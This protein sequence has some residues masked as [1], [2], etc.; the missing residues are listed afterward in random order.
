[1]KKLNIILPILGIATTPILTI[2]CSPSSTNATSKEKI[3]KEDT[4]KTTL[5]AKVSDLESKSNE[6]TNQLQALSGINGVLNTK[7]KALESEAATKDETIKN[8]ELH[9]LKEVLTNRSNLVSSYK[10]KTANFDADF[11]NLNEPLDLNVSN[12]KHLNTYIDELIQA[13]SFVEEDTIE[14]LKTKLGSLMM[15]LTQK[16]AEF[17]LMG[18]KVVELFANEIAELF[19]KQGGA[20]SYSDISSKYLVSWVVEFTKN[21]PDSNDVAYFTKMYDLL[22]QSLEKWNKFKTAKEKRD[23]DYSKYDIESQKFEAKLKETTS[24]A[25]KQFFTNQKASNFIKLARAKYSEVEGSIPEKLTAY[26]YEGAAEIFK[27]ATTYLET[28][29][30]KLNQK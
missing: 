3:E 1:M 12:Y 7:I 9:T 16:E 6:L 24:S 4:E 28:E 10:S 2:S 20:K 13:N 23:T 5:L 30:A 22:K 21:R 27:Q 19:K 8:A 14:T 18:K 25:Q 29:Y 17:E 26:D 11:D 15:G